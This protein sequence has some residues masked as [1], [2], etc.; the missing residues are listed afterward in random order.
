MKNICFSVSKEQVTLP[1]EANFPNK[2]SSTRGWEIKE[3]MVLA[4]FLAPNS[5]EK[6]WFA[7]K[8]THSDVTERKTFF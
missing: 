4:I 8:S 5:T 3:S 6:P 1:P 2:T 7:M